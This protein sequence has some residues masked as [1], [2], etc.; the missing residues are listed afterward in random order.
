MRWSER[1]Q[2]E[3]RDIAQEQAAICRKEWLSV[4]EAELLLDLKV[5]AGYDLV[6]GAWAGFSKLFGERNWRVHR[7]SLEA[8]PM[9]DPGDL[10]EDERGYVR[11]PRLVLQQHKREVA[12]LR[13]ELATAV[14]RA[15]SSRELLR[16]LVDGL[17]GELEL[18][19]GAM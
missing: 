17:D 7:P 3:G 6:R 14:K 9:E 15:Q 1:L 4:P 8:L 5:D 11:V 16:R 10:R 13:G 18:S 12:T 19:N 2:K